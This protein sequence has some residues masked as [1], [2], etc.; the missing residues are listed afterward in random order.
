MRR[1]FHENRDRFASESTA[2]W[3]SPRE[4][5]T[6]EDFI[7]IGVVVFSILVTVLAAAT[8]LSIRSDFLDVGKQE[9]S[10]QTLQDEI[11]LRPWLERI[12][13][14]PELPQL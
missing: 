12:H 5:W 7:G 10:Q 11:N 4:E 2:A 1:E 6:I 3:E 13:S 8:L 14:L 9:E